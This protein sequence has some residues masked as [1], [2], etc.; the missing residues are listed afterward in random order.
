MLK[1]TPLHVEWI[2]LF[3]FNNFLITY[4]SLTHFHVFNE[5]E[6]SLGQVFMDDFAHL[7]KNPFYVIEILYLSCFLHIH[8]T[9]ASQHIKTP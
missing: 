7:R 8:F 1:S 2:S 6:A 5:A 9:S 4:S 3:L